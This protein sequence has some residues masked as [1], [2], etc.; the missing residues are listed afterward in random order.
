MNTPAAPVRSSSPPRSQPRT[1]V[2][3]TLS[4]GIAC[5]A[6]LAGCP[7]SLEGD[8]PAPGSLS[9]SGGMTGSGSGGMTGSGSGGSMGNVCDAPNR[10]FKP[11]CGGGA[12]HGIISPLIAV[13]DPSGVL[14]DKM[15]GSVCSETKYVNPT[16]P[17]SGVLIKRL[18]GTDCGAQMP[19]LLPPLS[20][21]DLKC[22]TDWIESK[23][24]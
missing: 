6:M 16:K 24:P 7:G 19:S 9:G 3:L 17:A 15:A 1:P 21:D 5:L 18:T 14:I 22:V 4:L 23:L 13:D 2:A 11:T 20:A 8:F 10:I 12:C